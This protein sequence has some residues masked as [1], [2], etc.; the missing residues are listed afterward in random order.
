M[1]VENYSNISNQQILSLKH[2]V[3][4]V[5]FIYRSANGLKLAFTCKCIPGTFIN[6]KNATYKCIIVLLFFSI[7]MPICNILE[8]DAFY[9]KVNIAINTSLLKP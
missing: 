9:I 2:E 3:H 7:R 6:D 8:H 4:E 1:H 5:S